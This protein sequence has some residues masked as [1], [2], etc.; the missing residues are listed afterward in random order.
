[1]SLSPGQIVGPYRVVEKIGEGGMGEVFRA[2]DARLKRDAALKVLPASAVGDPDRRRRFE[3]EA[4]VLAALD[5]PSIARVHGVE[6]DGDEPIIVME[7]VDGATLADRLKKGALP[8][9][10]VISIALHIAD[11][12]EAAHERNIIHRDLKPANIK[13]RPDGTI[14]ILDFGI[15]RVLSTDAVADTSNS[16]TMLGGSTDAGIILG[17]AAYMS[18]EQARGRAVDKRADIWAF[19]CIVYEMLRGKPIFSG[20][21]TTDI[22]AEVVKNEP[23]WAALPASTPSRLVEILKRCLQK[24][25]KD[26]MRDIGDARYDIERAHAGVGVAPGETPV[27][28]RSPIGIVAGFAAGAV[29]AA[30]VFVIARPRHI[31]SAPPPMVRTSIA[32]PPDVTLAFSRGSA[33]AVAPDGTLVAFTARHKDQT[34]LYLRPLDR[35]ESTPLAGTEDA[36]NP[37]FSPDGRWV[38]FFAGDKLK[39]VSIDGGAPVTVAEALNPRGEA[40]GP[41]DTIFVTQSNNQG[42]ASVSARGGKLEPFTTLRQGEL[43]HRWPTILPDGKTMLF[44]VWNDAGWEISRIAAYRTGTRDTVPVVDIGGGYPRYI[45]DGGTRGFLVY[46]RSEGLLSATFDETTLALGSQSIP[47]VDGV[48]TNLSGGAH[49]D[50]SPAGTLAYVPGSF[51]EQTRDLVWIGRDGKETGSHFSIEGLTRSFDLSPD[52]TRVSRNTA[53]DIWIHGLADGRVTRLTNSPEQGNFTGVWST[54]GTSIA[55]SR[56]LAND[57]DIFVRAVD[58]GGERRLTKTPSSKVPTG[59]S[60]D[61][62]FVVYNE[63]DAVTLG[64]IWV[65]DV[66]SGQSKPI[67][68]SSASEAYGVFSPDGRWMLYQSNESGRF[69]VYARSFPDGQQTV[70]VSTDGGIVGKWSAQTNEIFYR[71]LDGGLRVVPMRLGATLQLEKPRT[72]FSASRYETAY[73]VAPGGQRFLMMPLIASELS[74]TRINV[75]Q[76]FLT[77]LRQRVK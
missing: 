71:A 5:H 28:R 57:V 10:D 4:Q 2:H 18:P 66:K 13:L 53:G 73:Q 63:I 25:P 7:F 59:F 54:D 30:A 27:P 15:A 41:D 42:V 44:S 48:L 22:L 50:L 11:G 45:R 67:V 46:A 35:F 68:K 6:L 39:K 72:L 9:D 36:A 62:N 26:R 60:P 49:F 58:G 31:E 1:V 76:N 16:P 74:S 19:G 70:R 8:I 55:F 23:D 43:S 20:E 61:G 12:L 75:I 56:G 47:V 51:T 32:L 21:S 17:T 69:E 34:Q 64:D 33:V 3:R 38:G 24:N 14:K 29:L 65:V 77:E 52:G 37:F 40:W